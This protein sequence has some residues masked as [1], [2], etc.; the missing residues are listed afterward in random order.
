VSRTAAGVR[1]WILGVVVQAAKSRSRA[2]RD[3]RV[4]FMGVSLVKRW[5][6]EHSQDGQ[7][8]N[9]QDGQDRA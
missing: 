3:R 2:S 1:V 8:K 5:R 4:S 7:D 6:I 9:G